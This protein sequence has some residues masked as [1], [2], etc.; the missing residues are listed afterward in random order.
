MSAQK[1]W[2]D[3]KT[4][5]NE[6]NFGQVLSHYNIKFEAGQG[7]FKISCPF[8]DD[9]KPSCSINP[10][11]KIFQCFGCSAKG[12]ILDFVC[13]ME[14][15]NLREGA[16]IL[17]SITGG[18]NV[19]PINEKI[20]QESM[21]SVVDIVTGEEIFYDTETHDEFRPDVIPEGYVYIGNGKLEHIGR[22]VVAKNS[23]QKNNPVISFQLK[24]DY[25]NPDLQMHDWFTP[26]I[27]KKYGIGFANKGIMKGRICFPIRNQ[28]GELVAYAGRWP[29]DDIPEGE[30]K[31]K[32][33]KDFQKSLELYL[34]SDH[35]GEHSKPQN[36]IIFVEGFWGAVMLSHAGF[37]AVAIMGRNISQEQLDLIEKTTS[38]TN[39]IVVMDGDE[40]GRNAEPEIVLSLSRILPTRCLS[41]DE[42]VSVDDG[43]ENM[44][45]DLQAIMDNGR[46]TE[47]VKRI[48]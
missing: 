29:G 17:E 6:A 27:A 45:N 20:H 8:H 42:G 18:S 41:L 7:D 47:F 32:L 22:R 1:K 12:N 5:K 35:F 23:G 15:T 28:Y 19:I 14:N 21:D 3:F 11:K 2:I 4:V 34:F 31:Y 24:L 39:A 40:P 10:K 30:G 37:P 33:P 9:N 16:K 26:D 46:S 48:L 13:Q 43:I 25:E 36:T 44:S 38:I